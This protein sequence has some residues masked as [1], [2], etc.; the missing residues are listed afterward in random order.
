MTRISKIAALGVAAFLGAWGGACALTDS[1]VFDLVPAGDPTYAQLQQLEDTGLLPP[2]ASQGPLTRFE[3]A[4][5]VYGAQQKLKEILL[6]QADMELP[7]PPPE[8]G[9]N[10]SAQAPAAGE[11]AAPSTEAGP[12]WKD[13]QKIA[14]AEKNIDS[15]QAAYD[16]ELK[17]VRDQKADLEDQVS[18]AEAAQFD[19]WKSVNGLTEYPSMSIHGL[20]RMFA[21]SQQ[22]Y[23]DPNLDFPN[24]GDRYMLGYLDL[25][26]TGSVGTQVR[27]SGI[28]RL[29]TFGLPI[30]GLD[31]NITVDTPS[32][33]QDFIALRRIEADFNPDFMSAKVGDF[34]EAYTPFTIWNRNDLDL[35]YVPE[36]MARGDE[37]LK[38]ESFFDQE[39]AWP[40]RGLEIG[41]AL[42]WPD[43]DL[44]QS[45]QVSGFANM[46]NNSFSEAEKWYID[47]DDFSGWIFAGQA[48]LKSKKWYVDD[49]SWQ[50]DLEEYEVYIWEPLDS[51]EPGSAY[52]PYNPSTWAHQYL[53]SSFRPTLRVG[54][55][56]DVYAGLEYE[57]AF[58]SYV[59]NEQDPGGTTVSDY[60]L[61]IQPFLQMGDS[62][63]SLHYLNVGP[64]FYTPLA[65]TRQ[66][67]YSLTPSFLPNTG[68]LSLAGGGLFEAPLNRTQFF[69]TSVPR[70]SG[71]FS[72]Y[73]RTE[74]N[75]FPYGLA[76]PNREGVGLDVDVETLQQK[77]L[78]IKGAAYLVQ[79]ISANI[80]VNDTA[81][82]F[83]ILDPAPD[84]EAPMRKFTYVNFGPS[85]D[86]GPNIG[87]TT[88]LE[89]GINV[90]YEQT[91]SQVG[92]LTS[93]DI[94]GGIRVGLF[95]EWQVAAAYGVRSANGSEE[96]IDGTTMA[97]ASYEFDNTDLGSY[98]VFTVNGSEEDW[99]LSTTF[100]F[101]RNSS[102]DLDYDLAWGN[103]LPTVGQ[104][105]GTLHNQFI[106]LT[107]EI[108]F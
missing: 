14:E 56:D 6:A 85:F 18:K 7:P 1:H 34:Y 10:A 53:I 82:G 61:N 39:P 3:V 65:Q 101:D 46:I 28:V 8:E 91:T 88:P 4:Q 99:M 75:T 70:P 83:Q 42:G 81:T 74:D 21:N 45:F 60:A 35:Y 13:P 25:E 38:Y 9:A 97:Q 92:T 40:F 67:N 16:F 44:L 27:W 31:Y 102:V 37:T 96:G 87:L 98:Q 36:M 80:V 20:G 108:E 29:G 63:I 12:L 77:S 57:G 5:R 93:S 103:D 73:D 17:L 51:E 71:I 107:Y 24:A 89:A 43:S 79:E 19:L 48:D 54:L 41:T 33:T 104:V 2:G 94:L 50:L 86:L 52:A 26:P 72:Y 64:N 22:Y 11:T 32:A 105:A 69:L 90:R 59:D 49:T 15:L 47:P 76:T 95:K 68:Y 106:G 23:G 55:G 30:E 66:D 84:G 100:R 78:K 58:S 62:K